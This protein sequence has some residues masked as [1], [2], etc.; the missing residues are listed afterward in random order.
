VSLSKVEVLAT[1]TDGPLHGY[2]I[3]EALRLGSGGRFDLPTGT[4]YPALHRLERAGLIR[5]SWSTVNGRR[6]RNYAL[7]AAGRRTLRDAVADYLAAVTAQL[8]GPTAAA[9]AGVAACASLTRVLPA[10]RA[11]R[12]CLGTRATLT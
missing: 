7:T 10:G 6:R 5:G 11:A 2:A 1:L 4:V 8:P 12:H 3:K 9:V